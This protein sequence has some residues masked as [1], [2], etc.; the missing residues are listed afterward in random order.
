MAETDLV[1][2]QT[3]TA[4]VCTELELFHLIE[5]FL[6]IQGCLRVLYYVAIKVFIHAEHTCHNSWMPICEI[7]S[8]FKGDLEK[9]GRFL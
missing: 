4:D 2:V 9:L 7:W 8:M 5:I 6:F 3:E 1:S